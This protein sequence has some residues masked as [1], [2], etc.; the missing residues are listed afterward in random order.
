MT[1]LRALGDEL[2][3]A[4]ERRGIPL[5]TIANATKIT[6]SLLEGLERGDCSRW[7]GGIYNRAYLRDYAKAVGL[8]A[9]DV[10][11]RFAQCFADP[12]LPPG[13]AERLMA[14]PPASLRL[15]LASDPADRWAALLAR[16]RLLAVDAIVVSGIAALVSGATGTD[17]WLSAAAASLACHAVGV[18]RTGGSA[19][20]ALA[21]WARRAG[22]PPEE[23]ERLDDESV[24]AGSASVQLS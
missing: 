17:F 20:S 21:A 10:V 4:R 6:R 23:S 19:A 9:D 14:V 5:A 7:P 13:A 15:A 12:S 3:R 24:A 18:L 2:R 16:A 22:S 11:A 8:P 1:P